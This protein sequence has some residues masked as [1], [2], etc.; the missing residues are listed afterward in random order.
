MRNYTAKAEAA[1]D[2]VTE[3]IHK[4]KHCSVRQSATNSSIKTI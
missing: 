4:A 2:Q 1:F 3:L